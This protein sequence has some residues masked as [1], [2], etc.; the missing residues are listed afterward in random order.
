MCRCL[1]PLEYCIPG[2]GNE[3]VVACLC[4]DLMH[5]RT[6][7]YLSN[8]AM[9]CNRAETSKSDQGVHITIVSLTGHD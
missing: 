3:L 7:P 1:C 9:R 6:M 4:V 5:I 2:L 8:T